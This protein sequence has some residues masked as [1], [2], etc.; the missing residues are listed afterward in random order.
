[1]ILWLDLFII[2]FIQGLTEFLPVSS[3]GHLVLVAQLPYIEDRGQSFDVT[4]HVGT[5]G[6]VLYYL[7]RE[8]WA[9]MLALFGRGSDPAQGRRLILLLIIASLPVIMAGLILEILAPSLLRITLSVAI[10][11]LIFAGWLYWA[12]KKPVTRQL[13]DKGKFIWSQ[14]TPAHAFYIGLAQICA[15]IPGASRSGVT[16][17]MA[18]H[19][20]YDRLSAARF[21][22]LLS[23]PVIAGAGF[24]KAIS[25]YKDASDIAIL[26]MVIV[27]ILSFAF[28][29]LAIRWMMGWLAK[30]DFKIF[31]YYRLALG[32]GL[33]LLIAAG[34]IS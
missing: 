22:L 16:M 1:M 3:S 18:R 10:V 5:L 28:A 33:I 29:M 21:S 25:L 6:A 13:A 11:N 17:S 15:L 8:V 26:D 32:I 12:D 31:V 14:L 19:L 4:A 7:R 24:L 2:S 23:L 30:A 9:M 27:A 20:G 34:Y